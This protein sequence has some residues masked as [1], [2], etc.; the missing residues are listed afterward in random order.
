MLTLTF[1]PDGTTD[2][3]TGK[4]LCNTTRSI[5]ELSVEFNHQRVISIEQLAQA[6]GSPQAALAQD[7]VN[8]RNTLSLAVRRD[9]DFA[10]ASFADPE[11]AFLFALDHPTAFPTTGAL[12]IQL[13]GVTTNATR[14]LLNV[15]VQGIQLPQNGWLGV[16]PEFRYTFNGG[17]IS[18]TSPF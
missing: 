16:A 7:L 11:A 17:L 6:L 9:K 4:V 13:V 2:W 15:A 12:R 14:Y 8:W 10:G 3:A 5:T 1:A 18:N